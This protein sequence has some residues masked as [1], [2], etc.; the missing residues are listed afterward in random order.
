[1]RHGPTAG[2]SNRP[3]SR[4]KGKR[5][6]SGIPGKGS[7]ERLTKIPKRVLEDPIAPTLFT[8]VISAGVVVLVSAISFSAGYAMGKEVG[9]AEVSIVD[10]GDGRSCGKEAVRGL[11]RLRWSTSG[12]G[13]IPV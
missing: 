5:K 10:T 2:A 13:V 4:D 8:W 1:M 11:R 6:A 12:A 7:K 3:R 9:R